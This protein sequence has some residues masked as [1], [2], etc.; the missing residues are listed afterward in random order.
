[1]P[2]IARPFLRFAMNYSSSERSVLVSLFTTTALSND[3]GARL[4]NG[5]EVDKTKYPAVIRINDSCTATVVGPRVIITAAHCAD[6]RS[7][8]T[9]TTRGRTYKAR[10]YHSRY[11]RFH[12]HDIALGI[13]DEEIV[14]VNPYSIGGKA[15]LGEKLQIFGYGCTQ[16]PGTGGNDGILR[17]GMATMTSYSR[18]DVVSTDGAALCFGDSGGPAFV[19]TEDGTGKVLGI[20]SKGNIKDT[21]YNTRTDLQVSKDFFERFARH[22]KTDIC[23]VNVDC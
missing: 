2:L 12:D 21:N 8:S 20:N 5:E 14:G 23:G 17:T 19:K 18:L 13:T 11:Y 22:F 3:F 15:Q 16:S 7:V 1:M 9:F 6:N 4:I 10:I